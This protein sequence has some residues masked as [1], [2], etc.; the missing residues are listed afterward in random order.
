MN[1]RHKITTYLYALEGEMLERLYF[2]RHDLNCRIDNDEYNDILDAFMQMWIDA[3]EEEN[4]EH[5]QFVHRVLRDVGYYKLA[6][7]ELGITVIDQYIDDLP[8]YCEMGLVNW[9]NAKS[10]ATS[11]ARA[12]A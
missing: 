6:K 8:Y 12:H 5:Q 9:L 10:D 2:I 4:Y 1:N 11:I 3:N 7:P